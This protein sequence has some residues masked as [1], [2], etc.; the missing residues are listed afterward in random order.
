MAKKTDTKQADPKAY[1]ATVDVYTAGVYTKAGE[2][3]VTD[4]EPLDTWTEK[5]PEEAQTID[6]SQNAVPADVPLEGLSDE[7][8]EA[9][10]VTKNVN[11]TGMNSDQLITAIKAANEPAL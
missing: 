5:T 4:A 10:A 9:I 8:L 1:T 7:A 6:A 3:F 2:V 11:P